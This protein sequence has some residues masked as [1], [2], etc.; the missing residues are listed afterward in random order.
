M[1]ESKEIRPIDRSHVTTRILFATTE[2]R[3]GPGTGAA[4]AKLRDMLPIAARPE[5]PRQVMPTPAP[6]T[7]CIRAIARA[8]MIRSPASSFESFILETQRSIVSGAECLDGSGRT[9]LHDRWE[10]SPGNPNAGYGI[11]SVLEGGD[12]LEKGAVNISI[13]SGVLTPERARAMSSRGR[14]CIDPDGGQPYSAA[15]MSLVFHSAHPFI[16][17]LRADVR[18]FEVDGRTW[19]GGGADLTPF[20]LVEEDASEFHRFWKRLCDTYDPMVGLE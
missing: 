7:R 3:M 10:R 11:T 8:T 12:V 15:A 9:F 13:V 17:T 16:P 6:R 14:D 2:A 4:L 5:A 20:Y 1:T 18:L 19:F